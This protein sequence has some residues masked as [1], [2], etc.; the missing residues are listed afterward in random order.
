MTFSE[1]CLLKANKKDYFLIVFPFFSPNNNAFKIFAIR[2]RSSSYI[3]ET[4]ASKLIS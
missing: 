2:I 3:S 4:D 1:K